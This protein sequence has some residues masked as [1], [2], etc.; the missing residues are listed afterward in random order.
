MQFAN[1]RKVLFEEVIII[2]E[3]LFK[4]KVRDSK[5]QPVE[6]SWVEGYYAEM[7]IGENIKCY[8]I[9]NGALPKLFEKEEDN[10]Y[11]NDVEV[12]PETVCQYIGIKENNKNKKK[13]WENDIVEVIWHSG[14]IERYLIWWSREMS[15]MTAISLKDI[16][17]NGHDYWGGQPQIEYS[18]FCLMMQDPWGDIK[19]VKVVG[20]IFDNPELLNE[21]VTVK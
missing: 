16:N 19:E 10:M 13:I 17:F 3:I 20:N 21:G 8:I 18:T 15:M 12:N 2:R 6:D 4:A 5:G 11:F 14:K 9:Q 1:E 7:G